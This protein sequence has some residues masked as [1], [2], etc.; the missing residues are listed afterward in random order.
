MSAHSGKGIAMRRAT[1]VSAGFAVLVLSFALGVADARAEALGD[2]AHDAAVVVAQGSCSGGF[3]DNERATCRGDC[4]SQMAEGP[5][6]D[7]CKHLCDE[8]AARCED[9]CAAGGTAPDCWE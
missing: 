1:L 4:D 9:C 3:C 7:L 5:Q 8:I 2:P 6:R